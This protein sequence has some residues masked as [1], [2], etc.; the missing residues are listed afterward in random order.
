M[1]VVVGF[2][3]VVAVVLGELILFVCLFVCLF[4]LVWFGLGLFVCFLGG[5]GDRRL[6]NQLPMPALIL[7]RSCKLDPYRR[8]APTYNM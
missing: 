8:S 7:Y 6:A 5:W 1:F 4:G 2:F 3:V